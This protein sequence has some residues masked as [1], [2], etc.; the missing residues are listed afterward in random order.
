[1]ARAVAPG[2]REAAEFE[3][4]AH[5]AASVLRYLVIRA[6]HAQ[7]QRVGDFAQRRA[8]FAHCPAFDFGNAQ[9]EPRVVDQPDDF[10]WHGTDYSGQWSVA[11]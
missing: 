8:R 7:G 1:M 2:R 6:A 3:Q 10:D 5:R 11:G 9:H 4:L